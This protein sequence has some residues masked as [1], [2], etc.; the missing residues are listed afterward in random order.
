MIECDHEWERHPDGDFCAKCQTFWAE[1]VKGF[2]IIGAARPRR[3]GL[4][5]RSARQ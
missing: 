2:N 4:P 5:P 1:W 3:D